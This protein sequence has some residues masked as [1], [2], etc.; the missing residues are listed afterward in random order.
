MLQCITCTKLSKR[1]PATKDV[2]TEAG[3]E[4]IL[5]LW[6]ATPHVCLFSKL[7]V[8]EHY[9]KMKW[10]P[11][12]IYDSW[13]EKNGFEYQLGKSKTC[14]ELWNDVNIYVKENLKLHRTSRI[15][16]ELLSKIRGQPWI[17]LVSCK[18]C[19]GQFH[20]ELIW[21]KM[22][23]K[24]STSILDE[25]WKYSSGADA[26]K[27]NISASHIIWHSRLDVDFRK[28]F[29][30]ASKILGISASNVTAT[31]LAIH[32]L[33][34]P[35]VGRMNELFLKHRMC[36]LEP[37]MYVDY[38]KLI[39]VALR[40]SAHWPN[41][42]KASLDEVA[43]CAGWELAIGRSKNVSDWVSEEEKRTKV[44]M[45]LRDPNT[46]ERNEA[47]NV[48]YCKRLKK[49]LF[50]LLKPCFIGFDF[51]VDFENFM[52]NR[53]SWV[54]SG[55]TGGEK[56]V[57]DGEVVRI[58]KHVLFENLKLEDMVAWLDS[59]PRM[60]A[61]GS[62]KFEMG[63][64][65]A[66]YGTKPIDYAISAYVLNEIEPRMNLIDGIEAGL[67]GV[68]V[69]AGLMNRRITA[70]RPGVECSMIDYADFNYQ[71][72]LEAQAS[73]FEAVAELFE[74]VNAHPDK[75]KAARW[76]AAALLNQWCK[77][78]RSKEAVRIV[79]GMFSGCRATN[80][81]N[82]IL[83]DAYLEIA[84]DWVSE[85]LH[86]YPKELYRIHQGDDV[87]ISNLSRLWSIVV[88]KVMQE[89]GF[90]FQSKKQMFDL[91]RAEFLRVLY[92]EEG[93]MGYIARAIAT[94]IMKPIQSAD[95]SGPAERAL[96]V[97][98][99]VN[100]IFRRGFTQKGAHILWAAMVP[101]AAHVSL[102]R[103]GFSL[104][105]SV[106]K[107]HPK[108]GGLGL[109]PPGEFSISKGSIKAVP[110]YQVSGADLATHVGRN[111]S[112]DWVQ[113][114]S[115]S[116][117]DSFDSK[118]LADAVHESNVSDS[119]RPV[120][121]LQGLIKLEA[122]LREWKENLIIPEVSS[123]CKLMEDFLS[124]ERH[125]TRLDDMLRNCINGEM[126]KRNE[127]IAGSIRSV[128]LAISLCPFKNISS[129]R[130]ALK[131]DW[132]D[133]ARSCI[134]MCPRPSVQGTAILAFNYFIGRVGSGVTKLL[135]D[136]QNLGVGMFEFRWH[137]ILLSLVSELARERAGLVLAESR[138]TDVHIASK[139]VQQEFDDAVR[140]LSVYDEMA[141]ISRY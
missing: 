66:I 9:F 23:K 128:C 12:C 82:T 65:R 99:Q 3:L 110:T 75:A 24:K 30:S 92:S 22:T 90:D 44:R 43:Q 105:I 49:K 81:L 97:N 28:N 86:L 15:S 51:M 121:K 17:K 118:A 111:M 20:V 18:R 96:A 54:S 45:Y 122:E 68:D 119:L 41:G 2:V 53:Q 5:P 67:T 61:V 26:K 79:Q 87:W 52:K 16:E 133:V 37:S 42:V 77:F 137:P 100:I 63:K 136:G 85:N 131:G 83:N 25:I 47:S 140:V 101:Y 95:I 32:C 58:N 103:G 46:A 35:S 33:G 39:S 94:L 62:E 38:L 93:C 64:A 80:F 98:S 56:M 120:D 116:V 123:N 50:E 40:R 88:F 141:E 127:K 78:P 55:S 139:L 71:H 109:V 115:E 106:I 91:C 102:P 29:A 138:I 130:I 76:T 113:Y 31:A 57:I 48:E 125:I 4:V 27:T 14:M 129:A 10:M 21:D 7:T 70:M 73:V 11:R 69:M 117:K 34:N 72:T 107:L 84:K 8:I 36:C 126:R 124:E 134:A 104:P 6:V 13:M 112:E 132:V 59:E 74:M 60:E 89:M 19:V 108:Q 1:V 114:V 135:M